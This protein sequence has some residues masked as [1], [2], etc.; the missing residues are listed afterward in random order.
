M[1]QIMLTVC[2]EGGTIHW[3]RKRCCQPVR[4]NFPSLPDSWEIF[5]VHEKFIWSP[6]EGCEG[7]V[8]ENPVISKPCGSRA[9]WSS[10]EEMDD[11]SSLHSASDSGFSEG[12]FGYPFSR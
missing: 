1:C 2:Q 4:E 5:K 11:G 3:V 7:L 9:G 10:D 6:M 8:F 12:Q